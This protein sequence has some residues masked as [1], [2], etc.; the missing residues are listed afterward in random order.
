[1]TLT[2][3][4]VLVASLGI[5]WLVYLAMEWKDHEACRTKDDE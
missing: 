4:A 5:L 2:S 1:M 3:I